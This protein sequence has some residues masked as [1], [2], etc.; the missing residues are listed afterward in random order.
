MAALGEVHHLIESAY[1]GHYTA[2]TLTAIPY[3]VFGILFLRTLISQSDSQLPVHPSTTIHANAAV[4]FA[5]REDT[6]AMDR[7]TDHGR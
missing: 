5:L 1:A 3:I 4:D 6:R 7:A 2:G